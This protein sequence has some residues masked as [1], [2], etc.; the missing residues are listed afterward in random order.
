MRVLFVSRL[1]L[2]L[3]IGGVQLQIQ[4]TR[5]GLRSRG[6]E[7]VMCEPWRDCLEGADVCHIFTTVP[8][9]FPYVVAAKRRGIP[10]VLTP[11]LNAASPRWLVGLK[12]RWL[13][14]VP[15]V[16]TGWGI[17]RKL[18]ASADA[19]LPLTGCERDFLV[20][21][22]GLSGERMQVIPN[23]VDA[24]FAEA[25]A[26][27]YLQRFGQPPDVLFVGRID[28][29]KNILALME[30]V[31]GTDLKLAVV[32]FPNENE[33][34]VH[35]TF[36]S[37]IG[38]NV[39]FLGQLD[40]TDPLLASAYAAAK[41]FC[42]PSFKEVMPLTVLEAIAA[43]CR[44]VLTRNS[45]M[46]DVLGNRVEY[47]NPSK[48]ADIRAAI[49][50]ALDQP[51]PEALRREVLANMTWAKVAERVAQVYREVGGAA[52]REGSQAT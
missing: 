25:S 16:C 40:H 23:G 18:V 44:I 13:S 49:L 27:L 39:R 35:E 15:G 1:D 37:G 19:V 47:V 52:P 9:L 11:I 28:T 42:L 6:V 3:H 46:G 5:E 38:D 30:A 12:A 14:K 26:E 2:G 4:K 50:R 41:V 32:G 43:R 21:A 34:W 10:V 36:Q 7:V 24:R 45:A 51:F 48:P 8:S 31:R 33:P 20:R 29:N 17:E 22:F